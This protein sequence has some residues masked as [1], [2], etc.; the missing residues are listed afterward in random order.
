MKIALTGSSGFIGSALT[1]RLRASGHSVYE[2][3]KKELQSGMPTLAAKAE[4]MIHCAAAGAQPPRD[5]ITIIT[6]NQQ[7]LVNSFNMSQ[8]AKLFIN[9]GSSSE[10]GIK[11]RPMNSI[12]KLEPIGPYA[13]SKAMCTLLADELGRQAKKSVVTIRP[14][15]VYGPGEADHR[16]IPTICRSIVTEEYMEIDNGGMVHDWVYIDDICKQTEDFFM[17][18]PILNG[19]PR[20]SIL[21]IGTGISTTNTE[22]LRTVERIAG[23]TA[24]VII[25]DESKSKYKWECFNGQYSGCLSLEQGLAKTYEYYKA[26]YANQQ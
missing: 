3:S 15:S 2:V 6:Q 26:K 11:D 13:V 5:D 23:Q 17:Y 8:E 7:L 1:K 10:Y 18:I 21:N 25:K 22:V 19:A 20:N 12:M 16:L 4:I 9:F 24:N 14:F